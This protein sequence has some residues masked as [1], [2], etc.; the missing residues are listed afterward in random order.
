VK[1]GVAFVQLSCKT[2][3][4]IAAGS[5]VINWSVPSKDSAEAILAFFVRSIG[6]VPESLDGFETIDF[7]AHNAWGKTTTIGTTQ[8]KR[9]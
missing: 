2:N 7:S 6:N 9:G 3:T 4:T 1:A 8:S 5:I